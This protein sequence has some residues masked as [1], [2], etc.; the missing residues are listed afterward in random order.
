MNAHGVLK[1]SYDTQSLPLPMTTSSQPDV[2]NESRHPLKFDKSDIARFSVG[3][4]RGHSATGVSAWQVLFS[5]SD[6][7]DLAA[8]TVATVHL[9]RLRPGLVPIAPLVRLFLPASSP[10]QPS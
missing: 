10:C 9:L 5:D 1:G 2:S 6:E 3:L 8:T 7:R 4:S